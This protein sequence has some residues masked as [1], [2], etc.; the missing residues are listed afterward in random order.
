ML[1]NSRAKAGDLLLLT[2]P[3]GTGIATTAIKRGLASPALAKR[4]TNVMRQ[5][6]IVGADLSERG[7]VKAATDI[8]GFGLL[9]HLANICRS[10]KVGATINAADVP[11]ISTEIWRLIDQNCVPG[12]SRANREAANEIVDWNNA[13]D[14]Q[15]ALLTDAQTSGG[16]LLCVAPRNLIK[17][18]SMLK[19]HHTFSAAI[20]GRITRG[21]ARIIVR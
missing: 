7:L 19:R 15:R 3:L 12:G 10:S 2:K 4:V 14:S 9:G 1:T 17:V 8:T 20:I 21:R 5:L 16:L 18:L 6:N 13:S 11:V